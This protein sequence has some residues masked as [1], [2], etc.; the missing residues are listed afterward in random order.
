MKLKSLN[1]SENSGMI[2]KEM[3]DHYKKRTNDHINCVANCIEHLCSKNP[4]IADELIKRKN[5]HDLSKW[6]EPEYTPYIWLTW[7][8]KCK[9]DDIELELPNGMEDMI[10]KA[11][12]HHITSNPHHPEYW[13]DEANFEDN[14]NHKDRD[15][16]PSKIINSTTMDDTS[17]AEMVCDWTAVGLERGNTAKSWADKNVNVRWKFTNNQIEKIYKWIDDLNDKTEFP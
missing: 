4:E 11:T 5:S 7:R 3:A 9:D 16:P 6:E 12:W 1:L 17:L 14:L 13:D 2:T 10:Q 8:Y 15:K